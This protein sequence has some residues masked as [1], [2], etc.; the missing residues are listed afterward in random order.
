MPTFQRIA[1]TVT[2]SVLSGPARVVVLLDP[3]RPAHIARFVMAV[4][5]DAIKR[6]VHRWTRADV[7]I[8]GGE[9]LTPLLADL[10]TAAAVVLIFLGFGVVAPLQHVPPDGALRAQIH[11]VRATFA[12]PDA[13]ARLRLA[14]A[15]TADE[16]VA[17]GSADAPAVEKSQPVLMRRF[18]KNSPVFN[19][20]AHGD[21]AS[22]RVKFCRHNHP[23]LL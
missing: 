5:V 1:A 20:S 6:Q 18:T 23:I 16:N 14:Y 7:R 22:E 15:Q 10:N 19:D 2:N 21:R 8:E 12:I 13:A 17:Y 4:V 11:A 3:R 9:T